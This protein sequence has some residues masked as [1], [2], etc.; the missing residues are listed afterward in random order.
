MEW[1]KEKIKENLLISDKW[2]EKAVLAIFKY[3]TEYEKSIEN[4]TDHNNVGFNGV[5]GRIM[6][7]FAKWLNRGNHLSPKQIFIARKKIIKYTG[8]LLKITNRE[9]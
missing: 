1:T 5:D 2:V 9:Q 3:Q 4:T 6:S 7:S 8:Q